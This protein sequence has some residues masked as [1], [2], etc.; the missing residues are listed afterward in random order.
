MDAQAPQHG[1]AGACGDKL[2]VVGFFSVVKVGIDGVLKQV[3]H[4]VAHHNEDGTHRR[5]QL[6]ALGCHLEQGNGHQK[7]RAESDEVS[8]VALDSARPDEHKSACYIRQ[9]GEYAQRHR[10]FEHSYFPYPL[11]RM[12]TTSPSCTTYS[13]PSRRKVPCARAAASLPAESR[14]SQRIVSARMK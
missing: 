4:T 11:W 9:S 3:D 8:Q 14:L 1:V 6:H 10:E 13:F 2:V 12:C 7:A 5:I